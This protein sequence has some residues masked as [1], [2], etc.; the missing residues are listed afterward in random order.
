MRRNL[1]KNDSGLRALLGRRITL[2]EAFSVFLQYL[3]ACAADPTFAAWCEHE[4]DAHAH[5]GVALKVVHD[6]LTDR[7]EGWVRSQS[8]QVNWLSWSR[9]SFMLLHSVC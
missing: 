2:K 8:W 7:R 5:F 3:A 1:V 4:H 6:A 9:F